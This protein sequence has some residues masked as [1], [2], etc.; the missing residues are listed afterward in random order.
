[1]S[2][3]LS[4]FGEGE[5]CLTLKEVTHISL[6]IHMGVCQ[7]GFRDSHQCE[8]QGKVVQTSLHLHTTTDIKALIGEST[9]LRNF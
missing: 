3:P 6:Y 1:V 4:A 5:C 7:K 2:N 8:Q 9:S